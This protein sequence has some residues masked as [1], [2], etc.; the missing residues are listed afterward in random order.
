M[1]EGDGDTADTRFSDV[2]HVARV[3]IGVDETGEAGQLDARRRHEAAADLDDA[4][5][6][7]FDVVVVPRA[8]HTAVFRQGRLRRVDA[9]IGAD[10]REVPAEASACK[11][12]HQGRRLRIP[13]RE[14]EPRHRAADRRRRR[15]AAIRDGIRRHECVRRVIDAVERFVQRDDEAVPRVKRHAVRLR[16]HGNP[17]YELRLIH[18]RGRRTVRPQRHRPPDDFECVELGDMRFVDELPLAMRGK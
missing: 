10:L 2:P 7:R 8:S 17:L 1:R 11:R 13:I 14:V 15:R 18:R 3:E 16:R 9:A 12:V 6:P 4:V 5:V